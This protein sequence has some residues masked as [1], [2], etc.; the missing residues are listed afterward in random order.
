M[1]LE[2]R[3]YSFQPALGAV[4]G[5]GAGGTGRMIIIRFHGGGNIWVSLGRRFWEGESSRTW[6]LVASDGTFTSLPTLHALM[7]L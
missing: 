5:R 3:E 2:H 1:H 4:V 7:V 6:R